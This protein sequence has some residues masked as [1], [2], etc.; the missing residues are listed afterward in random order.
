MAVKS[1][2]SGAI[3][4][5]EASAGDFDPLADLISYTDE[6]DY[7][8]LV[9]LYG[10]AG[11]GKTT[12]L[13]QMMLRGYKVLILDCD[14]G[15][16]EPLE[17]QHRPAIQIPDWERFLVVHERLLAGAYSRYDIV[18]IDTGTF[19]QHHASVYVGMGKGASSTGPE[20]LRVR[21]LIVAKLRE[22]RKLPVTIIVTAHE[23]RVSEKPPGASE[24]RLA[25]VFPSFFPKVWEGVNAVSTAVGRMSWRTVGA[26]NIRV[27]S[28]REGPIYVRKDRT[29]L[30]PAE[31]ERPDFGD[32]MDLL[33]KKERNDVGKSV[34][35]QPAA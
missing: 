4:R 17:R 33:L 22:L 9:V 10:E 5:P 14:L 27:L 16:T 26:E 13:E 3:V 32:I 24:A 23:Q 18:A 35:V 7:H 29:E 28:F 30:L 15:G 8:R 21:D 25:K 31:V 12:A 34:E 6:A 20:T 1:K 2:T 19:L 11:I